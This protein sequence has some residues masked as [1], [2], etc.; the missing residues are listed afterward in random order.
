MFSVFPSL[1]I[2]TV[3]AK[4]SKNIKYFWRH[5]LKCVLDR[6]KDK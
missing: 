1:I 3:K 4:N 5:K 6:L 2:Q